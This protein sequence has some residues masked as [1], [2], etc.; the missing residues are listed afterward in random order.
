MAVITISRQFGAG[1]STLA[2]ML[3]DHLRMDV[4]DQSLIAE[5]ARRASLTA[6]DVELEDE[7]PTTLLDR[8]AMSFSPLAVGI[9][10]AWEPPYPD[11]AFDPRRE[12][13]E[14]TREVVRE[15]AKAG[16]VVIVGRGGAHILRD[17]P[18]A[19]HVF[20]HAEAPFRERVVME[21]EEIDRPAAARRIHE[22]DANRAAYIKQ[23]YGR[24]WLDVRLY[25]L[26]IDT[27]RVGIAM[28]A[29]IVEVAV[30]RLAPGAP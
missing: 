10:M 3:A 26:A 13:L 14:L 15:A 1:G 22:V 7:R 30:S 16:N 6:E 17:E 4:V 5:V 11:P 21:R 18:G 27:G 23:I 9:G 12:V 2:S 28:S 8:L 29:E 20:L 19:F 24:D 25:D